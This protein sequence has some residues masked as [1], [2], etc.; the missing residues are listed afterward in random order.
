M[1]CAQYVPETYMSG[2]N[3]SEVVVHVEGVPNARRKLVRD[4]G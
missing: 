1:I 2:E 4:C 3:D